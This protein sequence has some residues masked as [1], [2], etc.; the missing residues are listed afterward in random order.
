MN[1][2][3]FDEENRD[4]IPIL[5]A[6]VGIAVFIGFSG[7]LPIGAPAAAVANTSIMYPIKSSVCCQE[8][9]AHAWVDAAVRLQQY[10]QNFTCDKGTTACQ[11]NNPTTLY[12]CS[13]GLTGG[14]QYE[15]VWKIEL[16]KNGIK[17]H[18][19][20]NSRFVNSIYSPE[21]EQLIDGASFYPGEFV[22]YKGGC[23][24]NLVINWNVDDAVRQVTVAALVNP[25][26][27]IKYIDTQLVSYKPFGEYTTI[28]NTPLCIQNQDAR[29]QAG[30]T[31][32]DKGLF[33]QIIT[34]AT[35]IFGTNSQTT[36]K[37]DIGYL[38]D[39][40]NNQL[41]PGQCYS[42]VALWYP[43]PSYMNMNPMGQYNGQDVLCAG[44]G[45]GLF[46]LT[47]VS[48]QNG[49][50]YVVPYTRLT[51]PDKFCCSNQYCQQNYGTNYGCV[52]YQCQLGGSSCRSDIECQTDQTPNCFVS[53]AS[54][55]TRESRCVSGSCVNTDSQVACCPN[56]C[57]QQGS[58][59]DY[60]KGCIPSVCTYHSAL[61][62]YGDGDLWWA[63]SCG[64]KQDL[65]KQC[66]M[67]C[68]YASATCNTEPPRT[69]AWWEIWCSN[70][71]GGVNEQFIT[72]TF[73][74]VVLGMLGMVLGSAIPGIGNVAGGV[75]GVI[76][77]G[78]VG[79]VGGAVLIALKPY[80]AVLGFLIGGIYAY[81]FLDRIDQKGIRTILAAI[82][83]IVA[84]YIAYT[85]FVYGIIIL[86]LYW[87]I[88]IAVGT[89]GGPA[90]MARKF[91]K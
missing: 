19:Y 52:N 16:Y 70:N 58:Y 56:V 29:A 36:G 85:S 37:S 81:D 72:M 35:Q 74:A 18:T 13:G 79:Y 7:Y 75:T 26:P 47:T 33:D 66:T 8:V 78:L 63:D 38:A 28:S 20:C 2:N 71:G 90:G 82:L 40:N 41:R 39:L 17:T 53:G 91:I 51:A 49:A 69:C 10:S 15:K 67:G 57:T 60:T 32:V 62:C 6:V 84:A 68:N 31:P 87:L 34:A 14:Y 46:K 80:V 23:L 30:N 64:N 48:T 42:A 50:N 25:S 22:S 9:G 88:K 45:T 61:V 11:L 65:F 5:L 83:G 27:F 86:V 54:Y 3:I 24:D 89:A 1:Y 59:C 4:L 21:C 55:Y 76:L 43:V 44:E 73:G 12:T 77:G